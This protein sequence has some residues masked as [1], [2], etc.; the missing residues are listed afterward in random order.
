MQRYFVPASS[1]DTDRLCITG[2]DAHHIS[3]VMRCK[4]GDEVICSHPDGKA[5]ACKITEIKENE[6]ILLVMQWL[7][8]DA[9][10]PI[11]VTIAQGLPKADKMELILQKGTELGASAFIPFKAQRSVVKWDDK[12]MAKKMDRFAKIVKEASE[13]SHRNKIPKLHEQMN[14]NQLILES[15]SYDICIFAYEEEAKVANFNSFSTIVKKMNKGQRMLVCIGPEGGF[16]TEEVQLLKKNG[17]FPVRL[18]PRI[19]RT[20]TAAMY[21]LAGISYQFEE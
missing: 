1:W 2:Q 13:Q 7:D 12:K 5:A 8:R 10:L 18:G 11:A 17:F 16:T 9:E 21:V 15:K 6:V 14:I 3:H 4:P 19:L 20:E